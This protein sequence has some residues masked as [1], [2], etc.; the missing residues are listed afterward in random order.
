M[1]TVALVRRS[2]ILGIYRLKLEPKCFE[3][4]SHVGVLHRR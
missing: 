1:G 3:D 2:Q 4:G